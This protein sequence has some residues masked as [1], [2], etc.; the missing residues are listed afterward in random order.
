MNE[1]KELARQ[2]A[3]HH[4]KQILKHLGEDP[5]REGLKDTPK[6]YIKMLEEFFDVPE[7]KMTTFENEGI[8]EMIIVKN[9]PFFSFCEHHIAPFFGTASIAYIPDK[10]ILGLSKLPRVLDLFSRRLQNQE[11][12]TKQVADYI[13]EKANPLGVGVRLEAR[14]LCVE[15]RGV[16]KH[17]CS[18]STTTLLGIFKEMNV[19]SEF[20]NDIQVK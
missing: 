1:Q 17:N 4:F 20:L 14:H 9:I 8:D 19:K 16:K 13:M 15:M 11:R 18:T 3:Q 2:N 10:T 5:E 6:R 7:F 12:I